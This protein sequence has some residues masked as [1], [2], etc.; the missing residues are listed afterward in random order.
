LNDDSELHVLELD[1]IFLVEAAAFLS[2]VDKT[3]VEGKEELTRP[4][5]HTGEKEKRGSVL[6][7]VP[8]VPIH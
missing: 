2:L 8:I 7:K 5:I 1:K 4:A 6:D 3:L